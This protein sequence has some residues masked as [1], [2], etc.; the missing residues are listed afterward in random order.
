[1]R[2]GKILIFILPDAKSW[3]NLRFWRKLG[4]G[5]TGRFFPWKGGKG[6]RWRVNCMVRVLAFLEFYFT[7]R[8][9]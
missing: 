6:E 2:R 4:I 1:M 5:R 7:R 8:I 3:R 9:N